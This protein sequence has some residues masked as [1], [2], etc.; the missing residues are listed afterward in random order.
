MALF[1]G[2]AC[3]MQS[4]KDLNIYPQEYYAS[5]INKHVIQVAMSNHPEII[6]LGDVNNWREW[7]IDWKSINLLF[8][9]FTCQSWSNAG[10]RLG[11]DDP[12]GQLV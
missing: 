3:G 4:L 5:E 8:A 9:G 6:Q 1:D 10:K 2:I 11:I 7:N 12:R